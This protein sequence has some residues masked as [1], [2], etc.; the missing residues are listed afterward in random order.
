MRLLP[1]ISRDCIQLAPSA[2]QAMLNKLGKCQGPVYSKLSPNTV[3]AWQWLQ[4]L[5]RELP[6]GAQS[7]EDTFAG[8]RVLR[9]LQNLRFMSPSAS[10]LTISVPHKW[11]KS[12]TVTLPGQTDG[13]LPH[14]IKQC[15]SAICKVRRC[16]LYLQRPQHRCEQRYAELWLSK[17]LLYR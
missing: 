8:H 9:S 13:G 16:E 2:T 5:G 6:L 4:L 14:C 1:R 7:G 3:H 11:S 10:G 12:H 17:C 15:P